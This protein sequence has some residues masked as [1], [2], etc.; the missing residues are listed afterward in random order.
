MANEVKQ[1]VIF[2]DPHLGVNRTS[3]TTPQSRKR[4]KEAVDDILADLPGMYVPTNPEALLC[5]LGDVFDQY[6]TDPET[7]LQGYNLIRRTLVTLIGNHDVSN[8]T[9]EES[10]MS[11]VRYIAEIS[12]QSIIKI[13]GIESAAIIAVHHELTQELFEQALESAVTSG[14]L[15]KSTILFLHC[16]YDSPFA[17]NESTLNLSRETAEQLLEVFKYIFIG[18]EHMYRTDFDG[19]LILVGNT[20]PTSF[21]DISDKYYWTLDVTEQGFGIPEKHLI[22]AEM[23]GFWRTDW[24]ELY[25]LIELND[26]V[27]FVEVTGEAPSKLLPEISKLV[28]DIW[29]KGEGLLMVKNSVKAVQEQLENVEV[30]TAGTPSIP[31]RISQMLAGSDLESIWKSYLEQLGEQA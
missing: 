31:E 21:A 7:L 22:W 8:R 26:T 5:C 17:H 25:Y 14:G 18:H 19:R 23:P 29:N 20:H 2:S 4:L 13:P 28:L 24:Q 9:D 1:L 6:K 3:H 10:A 15:F 11:V 27:Q 16:N 30:D 12:R